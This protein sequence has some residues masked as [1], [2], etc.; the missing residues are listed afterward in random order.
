MRRIPNAI[1]RA[2]QLASR[3]YG[4]ISRRQARAAGLTPD[5][6]G[7]Q[8]V[9]RRW[10]VAVRGVYR[11]AGAPVT[12][13]QCTMV[14]CLAGPK[15][16]VASHLTAA[17]LFG[18]ARPPKVPHVTVP[19]RSSGRFQGA[20][21][22]KA[23]LGRL[24]VCTVGPIPST[25][26][27]RTLVDCAALVSFEPLC[28]LVDPALCREL[29]DTAGLREAA[30]RASRSPGRKGLPVLEEVLAVWT[31]GPLPGSPAEMRLVRRLVA[32]GFP[33]PERQITVV[34]EHGV[35]LGR[36][37]L[38][39]PGRRLAVE[40]DGG[41][42]HTPRQWASDEA[43]EYAI[44]QLRW[45]IERVDRFDLRRSSSWLREVLGRHFADDVLGV[46]VV[47]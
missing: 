26:L 45:R 25:R 46:A 20:A 39:W 7:G 29:A 41:E 24:D 5:Q 30:A 3:Q 31:P 10:L 34:D 28:N 2:N 37:D 21:V 18:L 11:V 13:Q 8:L 42:W 15:G 16:T 33:V 4:A 44:E 6:I 23:D 9:A 22:H 32:W 35:F 19:A 12:W 17:A 40:Y 47:A 38:G 14:A 36:V 43:R 27:A 1:E